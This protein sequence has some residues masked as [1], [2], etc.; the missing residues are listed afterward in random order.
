[1][2]LSSVLWS[3]QARSYCLPCEGQH[4][5]QGSFEATPHAVLA[6]RPSVCP[7]LAMGTLSLPSTRVSTLGEFACT[8]PSYCPVSVYPWLRFTLFPQLPTCRCGQFDTT[9]KVRK[10][11]RNEKNQRTRSDRLP[12]PQTTVTTDGNT[13]LSAS[14][15]DLQHAAKEERTWPAPRHT[16][17]VRMVAAPMRRL[18]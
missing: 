12:S 6:R 4:S 5:A 11:R 8:W 16:A 17:I 10:C 13:I 15:S 18:S 14:N 9:H 1:M 3:K 2:R 7:G